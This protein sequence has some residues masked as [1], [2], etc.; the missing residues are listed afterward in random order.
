MGGNSP[1]VLLR[2]YRRARHRSRDRPSIMFLGRALFHADAGHRRL[3]RAQT[4][5]A[6]VRMRSVS[7]M[8]TSA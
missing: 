3:R 8:A 1:T 4:L 5:R 2:S 7:T 6:A